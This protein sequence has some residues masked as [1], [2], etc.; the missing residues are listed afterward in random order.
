MTA[1]GAAAKPRRAAR[2]GITAVVASDG[3]VADW[4]RR[5]AASLGRPPARAER[6]RLLAGLGQAP[7]RAARFL[8]GQVL[9]R[10]RGTRV[11]AARIVEVEAYLGQADPAAHAFRGRTAR[12]APLWGA[13]G[14]LYVYF[15]YGMHHC[16]NL[17]ADREGV[18]GCVLVRAAERI[19]RRRRRLGDPRSCRGPGRLC[20]TL[21]VNTR[22]S[23]RRLF[24]P[25]SSLWLRAGWPPA[26]IGVSRRIGIRHA[27]RRRLRFFD[28]ASAAVSGRRPRR[29]RGRQ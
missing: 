13:P 10:R 21:G 24:A 6:E 27:A 22:L 3:V 16:L 29:T 17:S 1:D 19:D 14:T 15:V 20:R 12:T 18:P 5:A 25:G 7:A 9:V 8:L 23:G 11:S 2:R 28:A 26:K 4:C